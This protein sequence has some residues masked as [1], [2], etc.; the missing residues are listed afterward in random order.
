MKSFT[1][2]SNLRKARTEASLV[3]IRQKKA[4]G[5]TKEGDAPAKGGAAAEED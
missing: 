4:K 3:G 1:A 2:Y 5:A